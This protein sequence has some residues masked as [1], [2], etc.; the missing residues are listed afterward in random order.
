MIGLSLVAA[1]LCAS[2]YVIDGDALS[3]RG[4]GRGRLEAIDAPELAGHCRDF[5]MRQAAE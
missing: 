1:F 5:E 3:C 2:P 4:V